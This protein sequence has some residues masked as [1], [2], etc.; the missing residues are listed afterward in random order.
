MY[1]FKCARHN[2]IITSLF[3]KNV[4]INCVLWKIKC[5]LES[6]IKSTI[7][8]ISVFCSSHIP[9]LHVITVFNFSNL[10]W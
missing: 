9:D 7:I 3:L 4:Q 8:H 2:T 5:H 10:G 6:M 1:K